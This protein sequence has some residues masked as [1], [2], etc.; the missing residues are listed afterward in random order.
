MAIVPMG[1]RD[2]GHLNA[3]YCGVRKMAALKAQALA[4]IGPVNVP[5]YNRLFVV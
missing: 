5:K 3:F 2:A 4:G 1:E